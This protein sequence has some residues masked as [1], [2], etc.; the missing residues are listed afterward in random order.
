RAYANTWGQIRADVL[1]KVSEANDQRDQAHDQLVQEQMVTPWPSLTV[2]R[3]GSI[4]G[5]G[6][7][8]GI[9]T[10]DEQSPAGLSDLY[11]AVSQ[12]DTDTFNLY[13]T[14]IVADHQAW[15]TRLFAAINT[16]NAQQRPLQNCETY[17]QVLEQGRAQ[18]RQYLSPFLIQ[19]KAYDAAVRAFI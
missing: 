18:V 11:A 5:L 17:L 2:Q 6:D 10:F 7:G 14:Q 3:V 1:D 8:L 19:V 13:S 9:P 4:Y 12:H 16:C 15:T